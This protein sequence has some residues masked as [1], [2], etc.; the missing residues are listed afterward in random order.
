MSWD[1]THRV[2]TQN[3]TSVI[4][5]EVRFSL[6]KF[7]W[8]VGLLAITVVWGLPSLRW[9]TL[10]LFIW[11]TGFVLL[12]GHSLGNHR[13]LVH[14]SFQCPRWLTV[15]LLFCGT[16]VGLSGPLGLLRQHDLRDYAQ[17]LPDCHDY[18]K[19]GRSAW[20]DAW[21]QLCC[22]LQ[23]TKP[24]HLLLETHLLHDPILLWFE[25]TWL[26]LQLPVAALFY[27]WGGWDYVVWGVCAR[28][29][30]AVFGHWLIGHLAHN[31][32][33]GDY[34][35][36]GAEVQGRNVR[37]TFLITMGECWHNNHHAYPGSARLGLAASEWDPGWWVLVALQKVGLVWGV[38][39]PD[40]LAY[41]PELVTLE[42]SVCRENIDL[43][44][45][46]Y[47]R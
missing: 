37:C 4:E 19:H 36:T 47:D 27:A 3:E 6:F 26:L 20:L 14:Q 39:L 13:K 8:F 2:Q 45:G 41:R 32:G 9:D 42:R 44:G 31:H 33:S 46:L 16:Q 28:I 12:F 40:D 30:A 29:V 24:P 15:C 21:W 25:R 35:I 38:V 7:S 43:G 22:E 17:R 5:G 10:A 18:L 23:L 1:K 11:S 34:H